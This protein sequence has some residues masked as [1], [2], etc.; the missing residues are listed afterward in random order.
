[1]NNLASYKDR[2]VYLHSQ[3]VV[4]K[5]AAEVSNALNIISAEMPDVLFVSWDLKKVNVKKFCD[6][7]SKSHGFICVV[8]AEERSPLRVSALLNSGLSNLILPPVSGKA[9]HE[10]ALSLVKDR[11]TF[12]HNFTR[13]HMDEIPKDGKWEMVGQKKGQNPVWR[14]KGNTPDKEFF[15]QAP[16]KPVYDAGRNVWNNLNEE[17]LYRKNETTQPQDAT[18]IRGLENSLSLMSE[19]SMKKVS[20]RV[21]GITTSE[22]ALAK[23]ELA[24]SLE[25]NVIPANT[26]ISEKSKDPKSI[27][28]KSVEVAVELSVERTSEVTKPV[29]NVTKGTLTLVK[30]GNFKGYILGANGSDTA[31]G[32]L[33]AKVRK[34]LARVLNNNGEEV[35]GDVSVQTL[36]L[37]QVP[38]NLWAEQNA[39]F[40]VNSQHGS[41]DV[42]FAYFQ[43]S[44]IMER[45][46]GKTEIF[47]VDVEKG[48]AADKMVDFEIYLHLPKNKKF[49]QYIHQTTKFTK[50]M[51]DKLLSQGIKEVFVKNEHW[52]RFEVYC[53]MNEIDKSIANFKNNATPKTP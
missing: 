31:D 41:D 42:A 2:L 18:A 22:S 49:V 37:D 45:P 39:E 17:Y 15:A 38:F 9:I 47:S 12:L 26:I 5:A 24:Q 28:A 14:L 51:K 36:E 6:M 30:T 11:D 40:I 27:M 23:P 16:V 35:G 1:M 25:S 21:N 44:T 33:A 43:S 53:T 50:D 34:H 10:K 19:V 32:E 29:E 52:P 13:T 48:L 20:D 3:G 4:V 46:D 7:L 8:F